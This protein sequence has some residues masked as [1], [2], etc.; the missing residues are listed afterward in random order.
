[1]IPLQIMFWVAALVL[2]YTYVGYPL[3][4]R[5]WAQLRGRPHHRNETNP[6]VSVLVVAHNEASR[7]VRRIE[8]LLELDYEADRLEIVIAS[9]GSNDAGTGQHFLHGGRSGCGL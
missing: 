7:I 3:L 5:A 2:G 9:D 4:V 8:N 1:M 6:S